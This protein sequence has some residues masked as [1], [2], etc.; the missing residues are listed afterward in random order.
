MGVIWNGSSSRI[1]RMKFVE[2]AVGGQDDS[3]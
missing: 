1:E 3:T 2:V